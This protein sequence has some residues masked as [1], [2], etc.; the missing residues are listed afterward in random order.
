LPPT[1]KY[2]TLVGVKLVAFAI[3]LPRSRTCGPSCRRW[4]TMYV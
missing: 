1:W 4:R 3:L 2:F